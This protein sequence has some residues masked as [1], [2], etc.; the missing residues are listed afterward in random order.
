MLHAGP[1]DE[2]LPN[3]PLNIGLAEKVELIAPAI[4]LTLAMFNERTAMF[5][6]AE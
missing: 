6:M 2:N 3:L 1:G 5:A 4:Q